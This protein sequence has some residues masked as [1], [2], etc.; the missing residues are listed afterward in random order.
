VIVTDIED[1]DLND[2]G[3]SLT[4]CPFYGNFDVQNGMHEK[5]DKYRG[6]FYSEHQHTYDS[7]RA[8]VGSR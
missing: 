1:C 4:T 5:T 6:Y 8:R 2:S 3:K 7:M